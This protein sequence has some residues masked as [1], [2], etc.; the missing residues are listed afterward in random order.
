MAALILRTPRKR[1]ELDDALD[2]VFSQIEQNLK[3]QFV[4]QCGET[5]GLAKYREWHEKP[6]H[7]RYGEE[8][9]SQPASTTNHL[10]GEVQGF[11]NVLRAAPW[12]IGDTPKHGQ[13]YT[14][15]N[16]V[17]RYLRP[18]RPWWEVGHSLH[19]TISCLCHQKFFSRSS[20]SPTRPIWTRTRVLGEN[21]GRRTFLSGRYQWQGTLLPATPPDTSMVTA[22]WSQSNVP[23]HVCIELNWLHENSRPGIWAMTPTHRRE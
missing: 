9:P 18:V 13:M 5:P 15:D 10:L 16:P 3:A 17:S 21:A 8:E 6:F 2:G 14:S 11:A 23:C 22:W 1:Q 4:S 12:R 7:K 19:P 20:V